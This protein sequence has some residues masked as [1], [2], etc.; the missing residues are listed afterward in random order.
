MSVARLLL[1]GL[2]VSTGLILG[3]FTLRGHFASQWEVQA[4]GP[5]EAEREAQLAALQE[6]SR[7]PPPE[8]APDSWSAQLVRTEAAP[9]AADPEAAKARRRLIEKKLAEKRLAQ[10]KEQEK[11]KPEE[12]QTVF[13]WLWNLIANTNTK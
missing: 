9:A 12:P 2:L 4:T 6:R 3:A 5:S 7:P 11:A 13:P 1:S 8:P 10:K